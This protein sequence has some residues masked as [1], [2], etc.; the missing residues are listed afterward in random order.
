M[1]KAGLA[2]ARRPVKQ[3]MVDR[4][5][6]AF[7]SGDGNLEVFLYIFLAYEIVQGTRP[8]AVIEGRILFAGLTGN[9]ASYGLTPLK[10][11]K[12]SSLRVIR[13]RMKSG[14]LVEIYIT[15][16]EIALAMID[17]NLF[18]LFFFFLVYINIRCFTGVF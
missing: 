10:N 1:S 17:V 2:Q 9:N 12:V 15:V 4:L 18:Q 8:K 11:Y 13:R 3:D 16:N 14:N 5:A 6:P 7:S